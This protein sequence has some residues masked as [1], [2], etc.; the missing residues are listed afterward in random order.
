MSAFTEQELDFISAVWCYVHYAD[1][2]TT[3]NSRLQ[4]LAL[5]YS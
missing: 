1:V 3:S 4:H 2:L 5:H